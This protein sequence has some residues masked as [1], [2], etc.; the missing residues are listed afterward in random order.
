[1]ASADYAKAAHAHAIA[2]NLDIPFGAAWRIATCLHKRSYRTKEEADEDA[3]KWGQ[4]A[5]KCDICTGWHVTS[6]VDD[7]DKGQ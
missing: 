5:Y 1:M 7:C 2:V 4:R 6:K 3:E